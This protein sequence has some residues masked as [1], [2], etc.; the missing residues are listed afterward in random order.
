MMK[1]KTMKNKLVL[2]LCGI[3][4]TILCIH[5]LYAKSEKVGSNLSKVLVIFSSA[6]GEIDEN[7]RLL[8]MLISHFTTNITFKSSAEV[9][10]EDFK[11]VTNLFYYGHVKEELP[12]SVRQMIDSYKGS[13]IAI[14]YNVEQLGQ[15]YSFIEP[16][17][18]GN[19]TEITFSNEDTTVINFETKQMMR[20]NVDSQAN[21]LLY[22]KESDKVS[23]LFVQNKE[24]YYY[25]AID[26][27]PPISNYFAE[28]L[29]EVFKDNHHIVAT[30]AFI[31][32]EGVHPVVD[33]DTLQEIAEVLKAKNIPYMVSVTPVYL[34]PKTDEEYHFIDNPKLIDTLI[35]MQ[36]NGGSI[37]LHGYTS[38]F[39]LSKTEEGFEF[40]DLKNNQPI[41]QSPQ[42]NPPLANL[43]SGEQLDFETT[44][45]RERIHK[46]I[47]EMVSYELYPL[48]FEAPHHAMS[49]NGY[50]I[51][52]ETFSTYVGRVQLT[53]QDWGKMAASPYVSYPTFLHGMRLLPETNRYIWGEQPQTMMH[54]RGNLIDFSI[55]KDGVIG[56]FYHPKLSITEFMNLLNEMEKITGVEWIDLK[57]LENSV[58]TDFIHIKTENGKTIVDVKGNQ[59]A[60]SKLSSAP[61]N[62]FFQIYKN[63]FFWVLVGA[64][65][66]ILMILISYLLFK[67]AL[68]IKKN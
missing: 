42:G 10:K 23:P 61:S 22:A 46:G 43:S 31:R 7:Q 40:W 18:K 15:H 65:M 38:Q 66:T 26:L 51:I 24:A 68:R 27:F 48:A 49:Q 21:V 64:G 20:T 62:Q 19:M 30:Q 9:R 41:Y 34:N 29:H 4:F 33:A 37:I 3:F 55:V 63:E 60:D 5:P 25:A 59:R 45:I 17:E 16:L 28:S 52:S 57:Q 6:S 54:L 1:E 35:Y 32:L 36:N 39:H 44:Y 14:G 11:E 56:G 13:V 47:E 50:K 67:K 53:D 12:D 58:T 2:F 8:D